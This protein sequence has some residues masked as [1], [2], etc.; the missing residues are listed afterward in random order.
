MGNEVTVPE[1]AGDQE[2][3][4]TATEKVASND[5]NIQNGIVTDLNLSSAVNE[6][7]YAGRTE[8]QATES[9]LSS[10]KSAMD[11]ESPSA[12]KD[13]AEKKKSPESC[14]QKEGL[15]TRQ[16][17]IHAQAST[18]VTETLKAKTPEAENTTIPKPKE[19][20]FF[21]KLFKVDKEKEKQ[22][23]QNELQQKVKAEES[24]GDI[25]AA[26]EAPELQ[27]S[28]AQ[29]EVVTDQGTTNPVS[30]AANCV[31]Q[32]PTSDKTFVNEDSKESEAETKQDRTKPNTPTEDNSVMNFFKTFVSPAK[33]P[34]KSDAESKGSSKGQKKESETHEEGPNKVNKVAQKASKAEKTAEPIADT[35]KAKQLETPVKQREETEAELSPFSKLFRQKAPKEESQTSVPKVESEPSATVEVKSVKAESSLQ[36]SPP[37]KNESKTTEGADKEKP[38]KSKGEE[39][40]PAKGKLMMFFKQLTADPIDAPAPKGSETLEKPTSPPAFVESQ[41]STQKVKDNAKETK[42]QGKQKGGKEAKQTQ[43]PAQQQKTETMPVENGEDISAKASPPR[44]LEKRSSFG[45][46]FKNLGQKRMSDAE[47]QTDPVVILPIE[48]SK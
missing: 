38:K 27:N 42:E 17:Q 39:S 5:E 44:K 13:S 46:F 35:M 7:S 6:N 43:E 32:N 2:G 18:N 11:Q 31:P 24:Q 26:Q 36:A 30:S 22:K 47:V 1:T 45:G 40:K 21:D 37:D 16:D 8:H 33:T 14:V 28:P 48:K 3:E 4:P 23:P 34:S 25:A 15:E 9:L 20:G 29:L 10:S 41:P 19:V 12:N